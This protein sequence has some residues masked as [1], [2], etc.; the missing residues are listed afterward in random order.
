LHAPAISKNL[1]FVHKLAR[2]NDVFFGYH[3]FFY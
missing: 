2:D 3:A 1:I